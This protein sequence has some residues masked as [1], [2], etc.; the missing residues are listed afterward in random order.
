MELKPR[1]VNKSILLDYSGMNPAAAKIFGFTDIEDDETLI[2]YGM[3][4]QETKD[5]IDHENKEYE[6][7]T[8]GQSYWEAHKQC[9]EASMDKAIKQIIRKEIPA[10][11]GTIAN[12]EK[13]I[14]EFIA[15]TENVDRDGEVIKSTAWD[16]KNYLKNPVVQWAHRYD[17]PPVGKAPGISVRD[18]KLT[19]PVEFPP[20][21]DYDY[22]DIIYRLAKGGFIS[23]VSV[24][25][26][27]K[28]WEHGKSEKE[29]KRTY[30]Q[31]ELLEVSIVP[32]PSNP[33]A[34]ATAREAGVIT[35]K[36][37]QRVTQIGDSIDEFR[38]AVANAPIVDLTKPVITRQDILNFV[39]SRPKSPSQ[40]EIKDELDYV[41]TLL[42]G[43]LNAENKVTVCLLAEEIQRITGSDIPVQIKQ[44]PNVTAI[45]EALDAH[46][47]SHSKI[48]KMCKEALCELPNG[49]VPQDEKAMQLIEQTVK[50]TLDNWRK[51]NA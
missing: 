30:T 4:E 19:L 45:L 11:V 34:L 31:V 39:R 26:I 36:E 38:E 1:F 28:E 46:H 10:L 42:K 29:P 21:G 43:E 51:N 7:I 18:G 3:S 2:L 35:V 14:I 23:A 22:A 40:E 25:F 44:K 13:R 6:L 32:V 16:L 15:S 48:Y 24:G 41:I 17:E 33:D 9:M 37:F 47:K 27:P 20:A 50:Q 8:G 12:D 49:E 5:T